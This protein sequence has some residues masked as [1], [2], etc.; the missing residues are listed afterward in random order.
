MSAPKK[1]SQATVIVRLATDIGAELWHTPAGDAYIS[2]RVNGH[3]ENHRLNSRGSREYLVRLFY[4][5]TGKAPNAAALQDAIATL[6]GIA[7]FDG[8]QHD[9]YIRVAGNDQ[10][11]YLDLADP[12]W[13]VVEVTSAGWRVIADPPVRFR[14]TRGMLPLPV[15]A[16]NGSID[17]LRPFVNVEDDDFPLVA[18]WQIGA[19]GGRGP[20]AVLDFLGEQGTGKSSTVRAIRRT[21]DPHESELRRPP[22]NTEDVMVAATNSYVVTVDNVSYLPDWLS[23]DLAVLATGGGLSKRELYSD[24]EEC[25]LRAQRPIIIN[26]IGHV[27]TRADLLDRAIALTLPVIPD[28]RRRPESDF[29]RAFESVHPQILGGL[30]HAVVMAL[31]KHAT[32]TLEKLPRMAD[33]A[34]WN[35][36]AEPAC[37]WKRGTFLSRYLGNRQTAVVDALDGDPVGDAVRGVAPWTGTASELLALLT[38]KTSENL[39]KRKEWFSKPRQVSDALRRLAPA[40]RR[41][42]IEVTFTKAGR[43]RTRLIEISRIPASASSADPNSQADADEPADEGADAADCVR[44]SSAENPNVYRLADTADA[45]D[46]RLPLPSSEVSGARRF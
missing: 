16:I 1:E 15:P 19:L 18:G 8:E 3:R 37:P 20:F 17:L 26:G 32:T 4:L 23:D 35:V 34:L 12:L 24:S 43:N 27:V 11:V 2:V 45:A 40:L 28:D 9:V 33:F 31:R 22:R 10:C 7:K 5:E 38:A 46:A 21:I 44:P 6:N 13:R 29:W 25:I 39:T 36:A 30:L 41:V 42:G 14:R